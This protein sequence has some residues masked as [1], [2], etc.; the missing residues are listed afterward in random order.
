MFLA[1]QSIA[2]FV[3]RFGSRDKAEQL[4]A[5]L[6]NLICLRVRSLETAQYASEMF[7]GTQTRQ[8][9]TGFS[10]GSESSSLFTEFRSNVSRSLKDKD[11][12]LV[13]PDLLTRLPPLQ[14]FC[15]ISG[16][17]TGKVRIPFIA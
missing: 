6:N 3:V 8:V 14:F 12:P 4:L 11:A 2:D 17:F 15:F 7:G 1:A 16:H 5:N 13:S 9:E 10:T